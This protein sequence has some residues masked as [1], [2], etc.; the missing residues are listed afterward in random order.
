MEKKAGNYNGLV[1]EFAKNR[2]RDDGPNELP[3]KKGNPWYVNF[4][5]EMTGFFSL[6]LWFGAFL[7][8]IGFAI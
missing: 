2:L 5:K 8:F 3:E 7:C 1:S 4:L 6:L